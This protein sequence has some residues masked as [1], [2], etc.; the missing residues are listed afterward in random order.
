[1]AKSEL[2]VKRVYEPPSPE[3][4][5]RVLV[6]R[7]WPRGVAKKEAAIG[8][9]LKEIGPS[10]G[11]R[12]WFGHDPAKWAGFKKR[13]AAE[14]DGRRRE[15]GM[16]RDKMAGGP[17]TLVYGAKDTEHNNAVALRDYL[18]KRP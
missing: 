6:D 13:Y 5:F 3:D 12:R 14:L 8:L 7:L 11:L 15:L 1:M 16:L 17:V 9:W 4:G 10:D 2:R 18:E